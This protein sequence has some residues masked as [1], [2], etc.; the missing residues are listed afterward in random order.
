M[1]WFPP[2]PLATCLFHEAVILQSFTSGILNVFCRFR[3]KLVE[4]FGVADKTLDNINKETNEIFS[5]RFIRKLMNSLE[6]RQT[7]IVEGSIAGL[8]AHS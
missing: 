2:T 3:S 5:V 8:L 1:V 6:R 4:L 7:Y